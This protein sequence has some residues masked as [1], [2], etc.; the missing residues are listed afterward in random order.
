[1]EKSKSKRCDSWNVVSF[2]NFDIKNITLT[3]LVTEDK[4]GNPKKI[5][6]FYFNYNGS[7]VLIQTPLIKMD[8]GGVPGSDYEYA[9]TEEARRKITLP[10]NSEE[11]N[12]ELT[13]FTEVLKSLEE[14]VQDEEIKKKLFNTKD[15][16]KFDVPYPIVGSSDRGEQFTLKFKYEYPNISYKK[17]DGSR[18]EINFSE[19][20]DVESF[21]KYVPYKCEAKY[22]FRL[23]G[24]A[25]KKP[26]G[27]YLEY[28]V[29]MTLEYV[30]SKE[31]PKRDVVNSTPKFIDSDEEDIDES[32]E[33]TKLQESVEVHEEKDDDEEVSESK[34]DD[35]EE[36][37][38]EV[39]PKRRSRKKN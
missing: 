36:E 31:R 39:K 16:S 12:P 38:K 6:N 20:T 9:D 24:W 29:T 13:K 2:K 18:Q 5:N 32:V 27:K 4:D 30:Q 17:L 33:T 35:E 26:K 14:L 34:D 19:F 15:P 22:I 1:M 11:D 37:L 8:Y 7:P 10:L 28:G 21:A 23:Q 3:D 25:A